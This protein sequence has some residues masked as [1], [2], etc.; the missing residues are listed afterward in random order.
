MA[1]N[2]IPTPKSR[3]QILGDMLASYS[4]SQG[5]KRVKV[6][7]PILS[8]FEAASQSDAKQTATVLQALQAR[9]LDSISGLALDFYGNSLGPPI[10]RLSQSTAKSVVTITDSSFIKVSGQIS[11]TSPAPIVGS[12]IIYVT[13]TQT[14]LTAPI[15]GSL[16]IGRGSTNYEGP[17]FYSNIADDGVSLVITLVSPTTVF[18]NQ[19]ESV[20]LAQGGKRVVNSGQVVTTS[21][22]ALNT[23]VG[24]KTLYQYILPDGETE[25]DGVSIVCNSPG[26]KGNVPV[27]AICKFQGSPPF[28]GAKV[29]N[30][31]SISS[32]RDV[33]QDEDYRT[34]IKKEQANPQRGTDQ[35]IVNSVVG[36]QD[37][38]GETITSASIK[39][40]QSA[41][42]LFVDDGTGYEETSDGMGI[43]ILADSA[44]GGED[45]FETNFHQIAK[46]FVSSKNESPYILHDGDQL[47]VTIGGV[48]YSHIFQ[49]D[50]FLDINSST[51]YEVVS[52][53]NGD[54]SFP[55]SARTINNGTQIA[56]EARTETNEDIKVE[57]PLDPNT[58]DSNYAFQFPVSKVYTTSLY[59]NDIVLS[60]DGFPATVYSQLFGE[61]G[62]ISGS[63]T[64]IIAVDQTP[65][66]T[67]TFTDF[68]FI[69]YQTGYNGIG[70]NS[71]SAW[72]VVF[73]R[74]VPGVTFGINNGKLVAT[75]N[76]GESF[77]SQI[78]I[79]PCTL[80][81]VGMFEAQTVIGK[82]SDYTL[83]RATGEI[84]L[85]TPLSVGDRLTLGSD[86]TRAF[87]E[88][89][90]LNPINITA[91]IKLWA[92][93]DSQTIVRQHG[94]NFSTEVNSFV[95]KLT[96]TTCQ[97][98]ITVGPIAN[99]LSNVEPGD[100]MLFFDYSGAT[101]SIP[102][103]L[104][105]LYQVVRRGDY[106]VTIEKPEAK[107]ARYESATVT[108]NDGRVMV[109]GGKTSPFDLSSANL[110]NPGSGITN[111]C[112]I[113]TLGA[114]SYIGTWTWAGSL[115][116]A[117]AGHTA[118]VLGNGKV[119]VVGGRG[120]DG[121]ILSSAELYDPTTNKWTA[122]YPGYQVPVVYHTATLFSN[123]NVL[124]AG[125][126]TTN[127]APTNVSVEYNSTTS[128]WVNSTTLGTARYK[129]A[130]LVCNGGPNDGLVL[131]AG[132]WNTVGLKSV[133]TY[134][135]SSHTWTSK[136]DMPSARECFSL[137]EYS[138]ASPYNIIAI[139]SSSR[140]T[141]QSATYSVYNGN[142]N[143]WGV[144]TA[145]SA[146]EGSHGGFTIKFEN[147]R[148]ASLYNSAGGT[149]TLV[150]PYA[151]RSDGEAIHLAYSG[152]DWIPLAASL[153]IL[154][155][156]TTAFRHDVWP[157]ELGATPGANSKVSLFGG[158]AVSTGTF[159]TPY[160]MHELY[161]PPASWIVPSDAVAAGAF[162]LSNIS[163]LVFVKSDTY[164]LYAEIPVGT[165]YTA[166]G[167]VSSL[168]SQLNGVVASVHRSSALRLATA[169]YS[170]SL[171]VIAN[172]DE[173]NLPL[174]ME[175]LVESQPTQKGTV[176]SGNGK[177]LTPL[178]FTIQK[179]NYAANETVSLPLSQ[180]PLGTATLMGLKAPDMAQA[181]CRSNWQGYMATLASATGLGENG[182]SYDSV[183]VGLR[184]TSNS[185]LAA[186]QPIVLLEPFSIGP[187]DS[188][189]AIVDKDSVTGLFNIPM[190]RKVIPAVASNYS[191]TLTIT[192]PNGA[193]L[194]TTFGID[195]K[196]EDFAVYM[197]ARA[198]TH[199]AD[200]TK[201]AL[202]R[203]YRHGKDGE[204][205]AVRYSYPIAPNSAVKVPINHNQDTLDLAGV[206]RSTI[207]IVLPSGGLRTNPTLQTS[208][209]LGLACNKVA[210]VTGT[211]YHSYL[212]VG[213]TVSS[214]SRT[215]IGGATK[216]TL[217]MPPGLT[218][219]GITV[220]DILY[221]DAVNPNTNTLY[222]GPFAVSQVDD[223][224]GSDFNVWVGAGILCESNAPILS[225]SNPGTVSID[226][227][228]K[229][230]F[231]TSVQ[232]GDLV[233]LTNT[234]NG[235]ASKYT[236]TTMKV[237]S[238]SS[239]FQWLYCSFLNLGGAIDNQPPVYTQLASPSL[240]Q[241]FSG[242]TQTV[243][244]IVSSVNALAAITNSTVPITG[245]VLGDGTGVISLA[246]WDESNTQ[247]TYYPLT[248]GV[249]FVEK[250]IPPDISTGNIQLL[251]KAP[252]NSNLS[253]NSDWLN[254]DIRLASQTSDNVVEWFN[255]P[256]ATGLW[257]KAEIVD[258]INGNIQI[259]SN[260]FG[261]ESGI[262]IL[263][264]TANSSYASVYGS[265]HVNEPQNGDAA[266]ALITIKRSDSDGFVG[267]R[268]VEITNTNRLSKPGII[269]LQIAE[270]VLSINSI[271]KTWTIS[272]PL[273][274][275]T[276]YVREDRVVEIQ[277]VGRYVCISMD[278]GAM[279]YG[280]IDQTGYLHIEN[281][282][283]PHSR[284][285]NTALSNQGTFP[286][287]AC[288]LVDSRILVWIENSQAI[289]ESSYSNIHFREFNSLTPGDLV[290]VSSN[291]FGVGNRKTYT[292]SSVGYVGGEYYFTTDET[293]V[294][295]VSPI[296]FTSNNLFTVVEGS[297]R[298]AI[299]NIVSVSPN[300]VDGS[301]A[302]LKVLDT[303]GINFIGQANGSIVKALD[304]LEFPLGFN[305]GSDSYRYN[306][307]LI[308][309]ASTQIYGDS[310][311][312][313]QSTGFVANGASVIVAGT[314]VKRLR[315]S[316][317]IRANS[318]T[319]ILID[320]VKTAVASFVNGLYKSPVAISDIM[321][322]AKV[323][324]VTA[325][326][327]ISPSFSSVS[328][329]I[330]VQA[331]EKLMVLDINKDISVSFVGD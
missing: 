19:G 139:G 39:R 186:S 187:Y 16:Y 58:I 147:S 141:S 130:S 165:N 217:T 22:G 35:A 292:V 131:V 163:N 79:S 126:L 140:I 329:T 50:G 277:K 168:N 99:L 71:L 257:S 298:K 129:H 173:S 40:S 127:N 319:Q 175:K 297:Q 225:G 238:V 120:T 94:V 37:D 198:Q 313:T 63:Q 18:H 194:V 10:L 107:V 246:S 230:A 138:T 275:S 77:E 161:T 195:Y 119:L 191:N 318:R 295:S 262:E 264:G 6:G 249:N 310:L 178:D 76:K 92:A 25:L 190:F 250:T 231:P 85:K 265:M 276:S 93:V 133:E 287:L 170:G 216:L 52:S 146:Y 62:A 5:L 14:W 171:L 327:V 270:T 253:S 180:L 114:N 210:N 112:E 260:S 89:Q 21:Q 211:T 88:T 290:I 142:S 100:W 144:D 283:S 24:F 169:N 110:D 306:T 12:E 137:C 282:T 242:S 256:A 152:T 243:A 239:A 143:T 254:E 268:W 193:S 83:D 212:I 301:Y 285:S 70:K 13:R 229:A 72:A 74:R 81:A 157:V 267:G 132:G 28:V 84:I 273:Y 95:E 220:G 219:T 305:A 213:Y 315:I 111:T 78:V 75:S 34:R 30:P 293:P 91:P 15:I 279:A 179:L 105:L 299:K 317:A 106:N 156:L 90:R 154:G 326:S 272:G 176:L 226:S 113:F 321:G 41:S 197:K 136:T 48:F 153:G 8:I 87:L 56:I 281:P 123:G 189:N 57:V 108:L 2:T 7:G 232:T 68:D 181:A 235:E 328:D 44:V 73:N 304:K 65:S 23:A 55:V 248:D 174:E 121:A 215:D 202:W 188:F 286:I 134:S 128:T 32:G 135:P 289:E 296:V 228:A 160:S 291:D 49:A 331:Y 269:G 308:G 103:S 208:T 51:A 222:S 150:A 66:I 241:V 247:A 255:T 177:A 118:T 31:N 184:G 300:Q 236:N 245:T 109:I 271:T 223:P 182:S 29:A 214:Y 4:A 167:F 166:Q 209:R 97:V 45:T 115:L 322:A 172:S 80:T 38:I 278:S 86:S 311:D 117:R 183:T 314:K 82:N 61:W 151:Q 3:Q 309:A 122:L 42:Y 303:N 320:Q 162:Y 274:I 104:K 302:D 227:L 9:D 316:L 46:A 196:F 17:L 43:E 204:A 11:H 59:L 64:F 20:V 325:V 96:P 206:P 67:Y 116:T 158:Y 252:I 164:P 69:N 155:D 60:K 221:F 200:N 54:S 125:G 258:T 288:S 185:E 233:Y 323:P 261:S 312:T 307:G 203:Y 266:S 102:S 159:V 244:N 145:I 294:D 124:I 98:S 201:S 234:F 284:L 207:D 324:G 251:L 47:S 26:S 148:I 263:G 192:E 224:D 53:I 218:H 33:E 1:S 199:P 27:G 237:V 280:S 240:I 149:W 259:T 205:F 36:L 330:P 101:S